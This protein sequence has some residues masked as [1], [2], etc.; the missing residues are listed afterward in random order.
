MK[1]IFM[2]TPD[3]AA[4]TLEALLQSEHEIA[5]VFAQPDKPVG[6]KHI[7]TAPPTKVLALE[8]NIPVYQPE[9]FKDGKAAEIIREI[10]PDVIVVVAY[11]KILPEEVLNIPKFGCLNGHASLLP[12]YRGASPIQWCIV[13]GEKKTGITIMQMDKGM[14]TG[15]ILLQEAVEIG[16]NETAEELF[17]RLSEISADVVLKAL[18]KLPLGELCPIKQNENEATYAPIIKKEMALIDFNKTAEETFSAIK[19]Y[20]SWPCAFFFLNGKRVKIIKASIG[21]DTNKNAGT[22]INAKDKLTVA[23]KNNTSINLDIIQMEGS[24]PMEAKQ[25]LCGNNIEIGAVLGD[26]NG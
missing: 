4:K 8:H 19:G 5:A 22:V 13:C 17:D 1:I 21:P 3:Y 6:R 26:N 11:G 20:Y 15:D 10:N 14:D 2:G 9:T 25:F 24:K 7:L 18:E 23:C 12:K 16:E